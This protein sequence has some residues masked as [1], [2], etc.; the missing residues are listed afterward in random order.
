MSTRTG[1][2]LLL[3]VADQT[4]QFV[5]IKDQEVRLIDSYTNEILAWIPRSDWEK[6]AIFFIEI[7]TLDSLL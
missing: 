6:I 4:R 5:R 2:P 7:S 1:A 3:S